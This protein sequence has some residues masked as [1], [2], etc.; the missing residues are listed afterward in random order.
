MK[1]KEFIKKWNVDYKNKE[2]ESDSVCPNCGMGW[3][4]DN[5]IFGCWNC[6]YLK[7]VIEQQHN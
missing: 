6:G 3:E 5:N 1:I 2:K 4:A 7:E